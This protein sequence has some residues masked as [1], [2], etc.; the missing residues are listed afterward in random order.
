MKFTPDATQPP[1]SEGT[2]VNVT[3]GTDAANLSVSEKTVTLNNLP[4]A[5]WQ[6]VNADLTLSGACKVTLSITNNTGDV[7]KFKLQLMDAAWKQIGGDSDPC[8][9]WMEIASGETMEL[10]LTVT[11]EQAAQVAH[12]MLMVNCWASGDVVTGT[13]APCPAGPYTGNIVLG[14]VKV[15]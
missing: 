10:T 15:S 14:D 3:W 1:V 7:A 6:N 2:V 5:V 11:A 9:C 13:G 4:I 8:V 12:I